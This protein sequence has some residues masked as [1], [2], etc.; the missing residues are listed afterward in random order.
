MEA[1]GFAGGVDRG[2]WRCHFRGVVGEV[3]AGCLVC[4]LWFIGCEF[5]RMLSFW[6]RSRVAL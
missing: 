3:V 4:Q 5:S 6:Q 1:S 2:F